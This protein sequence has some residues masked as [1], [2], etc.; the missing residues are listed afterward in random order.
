ME[1]VPKTIKHALFLD[2]HASAVLF[3]YFFCDCVIVYFILQTYYV[4]KSVGI[5]A[6][7]YKREHLFLLVND[8]LLMMN[9][10]SSDCIL[11]IT[12]C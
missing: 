5:G 4:F 11:Y 12:F 9:E 6:L 10:L 2:V 3:L 7:E 8:I 1:Y